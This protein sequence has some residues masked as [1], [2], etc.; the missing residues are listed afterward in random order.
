MDDE[1]VG[2]IRQH[3]LVNARPPNTYEP[4]S[5][6]GVVFSC[7]IAAGGRDAW[8][9]ST[10]LGFALR[11]GFPVRCR[12]GDPAPNTYRGSRPIASCDASGKAAA[13]SRPR[14]S[15]V[16]SCRPPHDDR[17]RSGPLSPGSG[18]GQSRQ[19]PSARTL[20]AVGAGAGA[21]VQSSAVGCQATGLTTVVLLALCGARERG[22][23]GELRPSRLPLDGGLT[24]LP[25]PQ[26]PVA[27]KRSRS[28]AF[29]RFSMK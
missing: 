6:Q 24:A 4:P 2:S 20:V 17:P 11:L 18:E 22:G 3:G 26:F 5:R 28:N 27:A 23:L 1:N 29:P 12:S 25:L 10:G 9:A 21:R 15:C 7:P 19:R 16:P 14:S 8:L 13:P